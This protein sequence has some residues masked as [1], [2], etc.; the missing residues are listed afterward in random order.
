MELFS[1]RAER[2]IVG[3]ILLDNTLIDELSIYC[4][5]EDFHA[6][7]TKKTIVAM[8]EIGVR[9]GQ[10]SFIT[11]CE[12]FHN[13]PDYIRFLTDCQLNAIDPFK[14]SAQIVRERA[15]MRRLVEAAN[16]VLETCYDPDKPFQAKLELSHDLMLNAVQK[17]T[18]S[19]KDSKDVKIKVDVDPIVI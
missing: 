8:T 14:E 6:L 15:D 11:L 1:E 16:K 17:K 13:N 18:D 5:L 12:H 3:R 2:T 4:D 10:F 7:L 9:D 19:L